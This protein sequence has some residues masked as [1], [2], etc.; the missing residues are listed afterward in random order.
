MEFLLQSYLP[1]ERGDVC[2]VLFKESE[3]W[4]SLLK[5][6]R[7]A[8]HFLRNK[9]IQSNSQKE[10]VSLDKC[11]DLTRNLRDASGHISI[12]SPP[13][14]LTGGRN[15]FYRGNNNST[16]A[17]KAITFPSLWWMLNVR[18]EPKVIYSIRIPLKGR[19]Q[20]W[21]HLVSSCLANPC[22]LTFLARRLVIAFSDIIANQNSWRDHLAGFLEGRT[23]NRRINKNEKSFRCQ[24][25]LGGADGRISDVFWEALLS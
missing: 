9:V 23:I 4:A 12:L 19:N 17:K 15:K 22:P 8:F 14:S 10:E 16:E 13:L 24:G 25:A 18:H 11:V 21:A 1:V 20:I 7:T 2:S 3:A 6:N 5:A